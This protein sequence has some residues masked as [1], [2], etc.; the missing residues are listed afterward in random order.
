MPLYIMPC[1]CVKNKTWVNL[2][3]LQIQKYLI[4]ELLIP[5]NETGLAKNKLISRTDSRQSSVI[6]G[7]V[8]AAFLCGMFGLLF[9]SDVPYLILHIRATWTGRPDLIRQLERKALKKKEKK[10]LQKRPK[11]AS[12]N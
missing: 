5:K 11:N 8:G 1:L 6:M 9:L 10:K 2:T 7:I 4:K 3:Q 12:N